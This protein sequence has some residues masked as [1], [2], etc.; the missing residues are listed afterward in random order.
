MLD[1]LSNTY[2]VRI[3]PDIGSKYLPVGMHAHEAF[4]S[5]RKANPEYTG[6][7]DHAP[8]RKRKKSQARYG[9]PSPSES[10]ISFEINV[11]HK[12]RNLG[13]GPLIASLSADGA[14]G[15]VEHRGDSA[16]TEEALI[17][18]K[19]NS[20][21]PK[22]AIPK[23]NKD[24]GDAH[25]SSAP[26]TTSVA[27]TGKG[28]LLGPMEPMQLSKSRI[29][30]PLGVVKS[31]GAGNYP[32]SP[33]IGLPIE[34][35][36]LE[37]TSISPDTLSKK[38][39]EPKSA[40]TQIHRRDN[41]RT[42][43]PHLTE[44]LTLANAVAAESFRSSHETQRLRERKSEEFPNMLAD[45]YGETANGPYLRFLNPNSNPNSTADQFSRFRP[46]TA[47]NF[48]EIAQAPLT[49][50]SQYSGDAQFRYGYPGSI[51]STA[52]FPVSEASSFMNEPYQHSSHQQQHP[53]QLQSH[54]QL[55]SQPPLAPGQHK[56]GFD[57]G[58]PHQPRNTSPPSLALPHMN[59]MPLSHS[60]SLHQSMST[61]A[62][63][64]L[65]SVG[66]MV[67]PQIPQQV[68]E[69]HTVS[70]V[71][72]DQTVKV[73]APA[74]PSG[75][76]HSGSHHSAQ[77]APPQTEDRVFHCTHPGCEWSFAR[78]SDQKRHI[79]SHLKPSLRC[80]YWELEATCNRKGGLF[81]RLDV[82][83]RHLKLVHMSRPTD[84]STDGGQCRICM[85]NFSIT[86]D[87]INH[88]EE[89]AKRAHEAQSLENKIPLLNTS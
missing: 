18:Q 30:H 10:P 24:Q 39:G 12:A 2:S 22:A 1:R 42:K 20:Y 82:L 49:S 78:S 17:G 85:K 15:P 73:Q 5:T 74:Q 84:G 79:R 83:K 3:Q 58:D 36:G 29:R 8:S 66:P 11:G 16:E 75:S 63:P 43:I 62:Y 27:N 13:Q 31:A 41:E 71:S 23:L 55:H 88:C 81:Y 59:H 76:H 4:S 46:I 72:T 34:D 14:K 51:L 89:C 57:L 6:A 61:A 77:P 37:S 40:Y 32:K 68:L 21:A 69:L 54:Q 26:N 48:T 50:L 70:N 53:P 64:V 28:R 38:G 45:M 33:P 65:L 80:P 56:A 87:F 86:R 7:H 44:D 52:M 60:G 67:P 9:D 19:A 25:S 35:P 47:D